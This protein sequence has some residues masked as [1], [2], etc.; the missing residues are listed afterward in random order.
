MKKTILLLFILLTMGIS[1]TYADS[2]TYTTPDGTF[3]LEISSS[4]SSSGTTWFLYFENNNTGNSVT[5]STYVPAVN[6]TI[7]TV[8]VT[9]EKN[10]VSTTYTYEPGS[11]ANGGNMHSIVAKIQNYIRT[12]RSLSSDSSTAVE[13]NFVITPSDADT[14]VV[15][16]KGSSHQRAGLRY[17][18]VA[19]LDD[20]SAY[21]VGS[22]DDSTAK[23]TKAV[24]IPQPATPANSK[25]AGINVMN[26]VGGLQNKKQLYFGEFKNGGAPL[27]NIQTSLV[28]VDVSKA[29]VVTLNQADMESSLLEAAQASPLIA[30]QGD[31][32][33]FDLPAAKSSYWVPPNQAPQ[34][35]L[36]FLGFQK[37]SFKGSSSHDE[38]FSYLSSKIGDQLVQ[39]I[40]YVP[41]NDKTNLAIA[42]A[43]LEI[44]IASAV[45]AIAPSTTYS[46]TTRDGQ[47]QA[48]V[49]KAPGKRIAS[50]NTTDPSLTLTRYNSAQGGVLVTWT[51]SLPSGSHSLTWSDV[52]GNSHTLVLQQP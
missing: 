7:T 37:A 16:P 46:L 47:A 2:E 32:V 42:E 38:D 49:M 12:I 14:T 5:I 41:K 25:G 15:V 52:S 29:D 19:P 4:T 45:V 51:G 6:G 22:S 10:G 39:F 20:A 27:Q 50:F 31:V 48:L 21:W 34:D 24:A 18:F 35:K 3:T 11:G 36:F 8:T 17:A 9:V 13:K 44:E 26:F 33:Q 43:D 28:Q 23:F 1:Q 40:Q 30:A